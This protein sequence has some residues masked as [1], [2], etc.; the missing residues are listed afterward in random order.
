MTFF[1]YRSCKRG[2]SEV[3]EVR[4]RSWRLSRC[5]LLCERLRVCVCYTFV[6]CKTKQTHGAQ[7]APGSAGD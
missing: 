3:S 2:I 1:N 4:V 7:A 5:A 6:L